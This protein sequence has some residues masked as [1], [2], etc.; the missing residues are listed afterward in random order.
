MSRPSIFPRIAALFALVQLAAPAACSN[1]FE[2]PPA[3]LGTYVDS[4]TLWALTGTQISQPS[5]YD[6]LDGIVAYTD[7]TSLF[8]FAFDI[9]TDTLGDTTAVLLPRGAMGLYVDG[10][11]QVTTV[12]F[13]SITIA[14]TGGY[15]DTAAV[16]LKV[17]TVVLAAS[18]AKTCNFGYIKPVYGK[19]EVKALDL[20]AR[21][22]TFTFL[23]DLNCGYRSL[24]ADSLPPT[25]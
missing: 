1:P 7:R 2:L 22:I 13:D 18:R 5:A 16:P 11:L 9:R 17:G 10:G 20:V 8:D 6:L 14:P 25:E 24:K 4:L 15:Q 23:A 19:F 12:P 21:S 3:N